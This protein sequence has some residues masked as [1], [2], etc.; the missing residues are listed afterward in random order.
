MSEQ[1]ETNAVRID[2]ELSNADYH[3]N[4]GWSHSQIED[5]IGEPDGTGSPAL[6][7]GRHISK[8]Y[9][10]K[11][12]KD[13]DLGTV[14]HECLRSPL[15]W[16]GVVK[17]IPRDVLNADG[18]RKGAAWK[19]WKAENAGLIHMTQQEFIPVDFMVQN[20]LNSP[21]A[22]WFMRRPGPQERSIFWTDDETGL[23]LQARLDK[24]SRLDTGQVALIDFKTTRAVNARQFA[25]DAAGFGYH[26][27]AAWYSDALLECGELVAGFV[28]ICVDKTPAYECRV[29]QLADSAIE[30]GREQ[31]RQVIRDLAHRLD[32]DNWTSPE[33]GEIVEIDLP[34][35]AYRNA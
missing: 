10:R 28:F 35:W 6:F 21:K 22:G 17:I 32:T 25:S 7:H 3:A 14:A 20:V 23:E 9:A 31:N 2:D 4:P 18:H 8:M 34:L 16:Q 33:S 26:R 1:A 19:E 5:L 15:G 24:I 29:Y 30:L 13:M 11:R 27:Q 12:S